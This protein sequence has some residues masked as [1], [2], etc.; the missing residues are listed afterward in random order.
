MVIALPWRGTVP[1]P[2]SALHRDAHTHTC[3]PA[4][5]HAHCPT[6]QETCRGPS[7]MGIKVQPSGHGAS[8]SG[9]QGGGSLDFGDNEPRRRRK[10]LKTFS[11]T[12]A[13][14]RG[15]W[16]WRKRGRLCSPLG[17][18]PTSSNSEY[19]KETGPPSEACQASR[20]LCY[21]GTSPWT[22]W[23]GGFSA[24][25]PHLRSAIPACLPL[26]GQN[27]CSPPPPCPSHVDRGPSLPPPPPILMVSVTFPVVK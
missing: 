25:H 27:W 20:T 1:T 5:T 17:D 4:H 23:D 10:S 8:D 6:A 14:F 16:H 2:P 24:A 7:P 18:D 13:T 22:E 3:I 12:P 26:A 19:R 21:S 15:I 9:L 11:L